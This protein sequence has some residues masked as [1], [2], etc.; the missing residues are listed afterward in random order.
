M[1]K[2][3][4]YFMKHPCSECPFR[5]DVKPYISVPRAEELAYASENKYNVFL[6]HKTIKF[7]DEEN[8]NDYD[9]ETP[10][11]HTGKEKECY[12]FKALQIQVNGNEPE[13]WSWEKRELIFED[14]LHMIEAFNNPKDF[15]Y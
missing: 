13:G 5:Q 6:C 9:T 1:S 15:F 11:V 14:H 7:S 12:G 8:D 2:E 4:L 10:L 3:D